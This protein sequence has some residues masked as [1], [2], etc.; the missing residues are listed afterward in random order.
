MLLGGPLDRCW[1]WRD[2]L[3]RTRA[4]A[5]RMAAVAPAPAAPSTTDIRQQRC[6]HADCNAWRLSEPGTG[7]ARWRPCWKCRA[8][9]DPVGEQHSAAAAEEHTPARRPAACLDYVPTD[10]W[11][12]SPLRQYG[13]G[14][15]W[16]Y[17]PT[18][19]H[20]RA[21]RGEESAR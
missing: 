4:A 20:T 9:G 8:E 21:T 15:V 11:A 6:G 18:Q 12:D 19:E 5:E 2:D 17:A 7:G 13:R 14:R 16:S 1:F 3:Q 10:H